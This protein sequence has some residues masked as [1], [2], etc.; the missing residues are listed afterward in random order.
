LSHRASF[1]PT[2]CNHRTVAGAG[3]AQSYPRAERLLGAL[4]LIRRAS[5]AARR[6]FGARDAPRYS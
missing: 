4:A 3:T 5:P 1:T 6:T 2:V